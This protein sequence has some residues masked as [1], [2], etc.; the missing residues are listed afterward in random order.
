[1]LGS[2]LHHYA[3]SCKPVLTLYTLPLFQDKRQ[4][5]LVETQMINQ[6]KLNKCRILKLKE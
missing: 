4:F 5:V 1:M 2:L 3:V 6:H